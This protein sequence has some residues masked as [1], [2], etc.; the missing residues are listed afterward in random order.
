MCNFPFCERPST[1]VTSEPS[2]WTASIVQDLTAFPSMRTVQAPANA[3]FSH[4]HVRCGSAARLAQ[5]LDKKHARFDLAFSQHSVDAYLNG[6]FTGV[7]LDTGFDKP[8]R[9]AVGKI[10][11]REI[12]ELEETEKGSS[13]LAN[14]R[15][16]THEADGKSPARRHIQA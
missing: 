11:S 8:E 12:R 2:A 1:V 10:P 13:S 7:T 9:S 5:E 3:R 15:F 16:R 4:R 14:I 6:D